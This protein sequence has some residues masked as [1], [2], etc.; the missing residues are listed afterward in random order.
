ML[1]MRDRENAIGG[2]I[3]EAASL[4][5]KTAKHVTSDDDRGDSECPIALAEGDEPDAPTATPPV[6]LAEG[7]I[8]MVPELTHPGESQSNGLAERSV[9]IFEDFVRTTI[10]ALR[11]NLGVSFPADH[12]L[13][14]WAV[15][16]SAYLLNTHSLGTDGR[17]AYGRLHGAETNDR[18]CQLGEQ[19]PWSVPNRLRDKLD[20]RCRHG[21]FLGRSTGSDQNFIGLAIGEVIRARA[22]SR[23]IPSSRWNSA[24]ALALKTT[25]L[26]ERT[27]G[28]DS[29]EE[30][31]QP[32][33]HHAADEG[34][35]PS[36]PAPPRRVEITVK[37]LKAHGYSA[38]CPRNSC[39]R[40]GHHRRANSCRARIYDCLVKAGA[41][42]VR[43]APGQ[44]LHTQ[45]SEAA[46]NPS[47][48]APGLAGGASSSSGPLPFDGAAGPEA[49]NLFSPFDD[50]TT[51]VY[52]EVHAD[53]E[54]SQ[55]CSGTC[56][57][58]VAGRRGG[59][60]GHGIRPRI[61]HDRSWMC[62]NAWGSMPSMH[63]S[64][65]QLL[66]EPNLAFTTSARISCYDNVF[67]LL[68]LD[69]LLR[70][71]SFMGLAEF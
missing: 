37:D 32:H 3:D 13:V 51:H 71:W 45:S 44:R 22:I 28:F 69:L 25:P 27:L 12:P 65:Q 58:I 63:A 23:M 36:P 64:L 54:A 59:G 17:T 40:E 60:E 31:E 24:L 47:A 9:G 55:T 5:G 49:A 2:M 10:L 11:V 53:V 70:S 52:E 4:L 18:S 21:M 19:I 20:Q 33:S 56:S 46:A 35:T 26:T 57:P 48:S 7:P 14:D 68:S 43:H 29:L 66:F 39:H 16:H 61:L 67:S 62:C 41:P 8:V 15:Q 50:D 34:G 42:K 38:G 1:L 30:H 6:A